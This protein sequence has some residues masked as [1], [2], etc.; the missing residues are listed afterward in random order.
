MPT[1][2]RVQDQRSECRESHQDD[3]DYGQCVAVSVGGVECDVDSRKGVRPRRKVDGDR[4]PR[5][6]YE[7][8]G[9]ELGSIAVDQDRC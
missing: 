3:G 2:E 1:S 8:P 4:R 9:N 5:R 7:R 6:H